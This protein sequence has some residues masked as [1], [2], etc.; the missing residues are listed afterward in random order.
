[1]S[2]HY[3][4]FSGTPGYPLNSIRRISIGNPNNVTTLAGKKRKFLSIESVVTLCED[5]FL[6]MIIMSSDEG[7]T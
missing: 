4:D 2:D 6:H 1:M 3:D 7:N 5:Y